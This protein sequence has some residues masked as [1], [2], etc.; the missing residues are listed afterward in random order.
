MTTAGA[1]WD[2]IVVGA[3][4]G[5]CVVAAELAADGR[6][7][8]LVEAGPGRPH[9]ESITGLDTVAAA[10][11]STRQ[12]AGF[13]LR[14]TDRAETRPYR[15][16]FGVGGGSLINS[17][18]LSPGDSSDYLRWQQQ[19]GCVGWGPQDMAPYLEAAIARFGASPAPAGPA[20]QGFAAAAVAAGH[21]SGGSSL[22]QDR[23]GLLQSR[24]AAT[25]VARLSADSVYLGPAGSTSGLAKMAGLEVRSDARVV[26]VLMNRDA[27][28][29][30]ECSDGERVLAP[31]VVLAGGAFHSPLLLGQL[32][33]ARASVGERL[34]DHPS[35]AFT[36][37]LH[38]DFV[39]DQ[40]G[41][42]VS[43]RKLLVSSLLRWSS[44]E[45]EHGDLQAFV[46]DQVGSRTGEHAQ[47]Y[48]VVVVGLMRVDST[49][50]VS[51]ATSTRSGAPREV[52]REVSRPEA[53]TGALTEAADR[54]RFRTGVRHVF[55]LL[56]ST[57]LSPMVDEIFI[58]E[59]G[60][61]ASAL[62]AMDDDSLDRFLAKHPGPY[63]HP[64]GTCAMGRDDDPRSVVT[65]D[66]E[67]AGQVIG[68]SGLFVADASIMP[69]LVQGG[70]QIPVA[71]IASRVA[72]GIKQSSSSAAG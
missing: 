59:H 62:G 16:G 67:I 71:A 30:I 3:G 58:D 56:G 32:E 28:A 34:K 2:A 19:Y 5:G 52:S 4:V 55:E 7:V 12:W 21:P 10:D 31:I 39:R 24:L 13:Q 8:L 38:D 69:D 41:S 66:P 20:S 54:A 44:N 47:E 26:R 61:P 37:A 17:L 60:T 23:L 64:A 1:D 36:I 65:C 45:S 33:Q 6:R 11:E 27:V 48:A 42:D 46:I 49:G 57:E 9:P 25:D 53:V 72:E 15:Q 63:A 29:G 70:L 35:F 14:S 51:A 43:A 18:L 68:T 50:R 22:D 40:P